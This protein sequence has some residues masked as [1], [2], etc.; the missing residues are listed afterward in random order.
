[1][2]G[3]AQKAGADGVVPS[4]RWVSLSIDIEHETESVDRGPGLGGPWSAPIMNGLVYR[5]RH[6]TYPVGYPYGGTIQEFPD[7]T[8]VTVPIVASGGVRSG[9]DVMGYI[10]AG[11]NAAEICSQVLVEGVQAITPGWWIV[12]VM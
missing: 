5:M 3:I 1:M 11:A 4:T 6:A 10:I 2:A 12:R 7:A 9:A 8:P